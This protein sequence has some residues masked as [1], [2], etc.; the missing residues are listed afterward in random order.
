MKNKKKLENI[1]VPQ[2]NQLLAN[3]HIYYQNLRAYHWN[4]QGKDFF[5]MHLKFEEMYNQ[6]LLHI[7]EIAERILTLNETPLHTFTDFLKISEIKEHS[8]IHN[9][10]KAVSLLLTDLDIL[11][12]NINTLLK[13]SMEMGDDATSAQLGEYLKLHDKSK[14]MFNAWLK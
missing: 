7:D 2:L 13:A 9:S 1:I 8:H 4:V 10:R 12:S 11:R 5:E 3:Y 6:S 14:W